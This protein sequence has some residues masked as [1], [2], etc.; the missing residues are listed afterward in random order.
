MGTRLY[1]KPKENKMIVIKE[2]DLREYL[3]DKSFDMNIYNEIS[4]LS[5]VEEDNIMYGVVHGN[6]TGENLEA[7][8]VETMYYTY[9][10]ADEVYQEYLNDNEFVQLT[11]NIEIVLK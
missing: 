1:K 4:E 5:V 3:K 6:D 7:E 9:E 8:F 2:A 10:E 11:Q